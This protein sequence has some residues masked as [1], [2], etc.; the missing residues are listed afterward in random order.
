MTTAMDDSLIWVGRVVNTQGIK[1]RV[2]ISP[3]GEAAA[4]F[5]QGTMVYLENRQGVK[6]S[7]TVHSSRPHRQFTILSF[8]E[9]QRVEEAEELVGCSVYV[10][11]ESLKA[12]P[13]NEFYWY[14]LFG[15]QVKT[16]SGTF[17]GTLEE[18][19]P[20]GSNDV[21]VVRRDGKEVLIPATDEVVVKVDLPA[22]TMV[23][24]PLEG[25]LP[26]DDL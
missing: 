6:K 4:T 14:Q 20:T 26:E 9:V 11:K 21:F 2:R 5:S 15:L 1:G 13:P 24:H 16:E 10:A 22:R 23:I 8:R 7:L 18:I 17:L 3:S 25:L 19:M 12:L